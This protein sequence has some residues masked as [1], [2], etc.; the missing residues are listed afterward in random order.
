MSNLGFRRAMA[1]AGIAVVETPVGDRHVL[2]ALAAGGH[3]LGGEQSGHLVFAD[4]AT[5]GDG[6]LAAVMLLDLVDPRGPAAGRAGCR[7]RC[8]RLP[9]VLVNVRVAQPMPD[10]AERLAP[11]IAAAVGRPVG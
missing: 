3:S 2:E 7:G 5:T 10:V 6:L 9:Q 8:P 1:A 4:L 11:Q